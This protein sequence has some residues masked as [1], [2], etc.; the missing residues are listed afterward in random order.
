MAKPKTKFF[1]ST[2]QAANHFFRGGLHFQPLFTAA[3]LTC[4]VF[5][6]CLLE[7]ILVISHLSRPTLPF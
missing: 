3:Q 2:S 5:F 1:F 7:E 4:S 6:A